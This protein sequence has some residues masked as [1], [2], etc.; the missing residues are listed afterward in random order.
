MKI[1]SLHIQCVHLCV[2]YLVESHVGLIHQAN[3]ELVNER[4]QLLWVTKWF[5]AL[6][7]ITYDLH[8]CRL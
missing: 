5:S 7:H 2:C 1:C 3:I 8:N 4:P 6:H